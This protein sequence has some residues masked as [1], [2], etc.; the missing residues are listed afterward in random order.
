[1]GFFIAVLVDVA[2][3]EERFGG[4]RVEEG[5]LIFTVGART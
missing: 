1:M 3:G 2:A 5:L 4:T